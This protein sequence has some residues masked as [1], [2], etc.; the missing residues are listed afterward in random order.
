MYPIATVYGGV[1]IFYNIPQNFDHLRL[2]VTSR[3]TVNN[4]ADPYYIRLNEDYTFSYNSRSMQANGSSISY[5]ARPTTDINFMS[6]GLVPAATAPAN[7]FGAIIADLFD[8]SN[9][10]K[11]TTIRVFGGYDV[12]GSGAVSFGSGLYNKSDAITVLQT[13][14]AS[15]ISTSVS[16]F[17]LYG[18]RSSE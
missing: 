5:F 7:C 2:I 9:T 17:D 18:I 16:R 4:T 14:P 6:Y 8:Y 15:N 10:S 13:G 11:L 1:E 3:G 12:N